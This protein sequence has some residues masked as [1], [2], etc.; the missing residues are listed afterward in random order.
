MTWTNIIKKAIEEAKKGGY[1]IDETKIQW[2]QMTTGKGYY[3]LI[4]EHD[5][6]KSIFGN[7]EHYDLILK[8]EKENNEN[9]EINEDSLPVPTWKRILQDLVVQEEPLEMLSKFI[10]NKLKLT[11]VGAG[12]VEGTKDT[13]AVR[14]MIKKNLNK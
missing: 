14:E 11:Q 7:G 9:E 1:E 13:S 4:F 5:F 8:A 6:V 12:V 3:S 2:G 10:D